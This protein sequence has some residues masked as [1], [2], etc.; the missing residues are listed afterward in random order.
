MYK[1]QPDTIFGASTC[2]KR[3]A[4]GANIPMDEA[5]TD[6]QAYI[7]WVAEGN[8]PEPADEGTQ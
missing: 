8:T 5:N 6:Y 7:A 2:I 1:L 4:D 3:I